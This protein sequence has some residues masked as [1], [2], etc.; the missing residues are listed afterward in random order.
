MAQNNAVS[1]T[2]GAA[3]KS[4]FGTALGGGRKQLMQMGQALKSLDASGKRIQ[5]FQKLK[6][7]VI[8]AKNSW[9][10]AETQVRELAL[11]M[12]Q[13]ANPTAKMK[14]EFEKAKN[15]AG[16][17]KAAY[18]KKQDSLRQVRLEMKA[19]GQSTRN[20]AAQQTKL[21]TS[22]D[23]LKS[24]YNALDR[25]LKRGDGIK[26]RRAAL[27]GQIL[28]MVALGAAMGA[29]L[30]AAIDFESEMADVRKVVDFKDQQNGLRAFGNQ[31]KAMSRTIPLSAAG[32]AQIAAAGG[33]LGVSED[34][35]PDFVKTASQMAVAFDIMPDQA[36]ESM[37]K[38]SNIFGIPITEMSQLGDALNH[39]SD[40]TA[41]KASEIVQVITR[42]GAQA[43]DFGLSAE[44][45]AALGDTFV[46]LGKK[47]EVAATAMNALLLKLNTADKQSAKF[48]SGLS[49]LGIEAQGLKDA[50]RNDAQG[51]LLSFLQ[52]VSQVEKQERA[53]ILSDLFGLEYADDISLLAGQVQTYQKTLD[54]LGDSKKHN[55]MQR[56][57]ANRSNTTKN[58]LQLLSNQITEIGMNIG[59]TLLPPLNFL[60]NNVMR[61]M[62]GMIADLAE[63]FPL[64][65]SVV[66]GATFALIGIKIAAIGLGY[67]WTFVL[68]GANALV[69]GFRGLQ[70]A[71]ALASL[72]MGAFNISA[73]IT[74][75]RLK[76]LAF[77]GMVKAFAASLI[78]L[79]SRAIPIVIG[80]MRALT[81][82]IMT[83]PIGLI[84]GGIALAGGLLITNWDKVKAFF[85]GIWDSV[86]PVWEAFA[87][88]IGG[89]W[90]IISAP[91]R[92]IGKVWD[93]IFGS[94][95]P[96]V[97]ATI[98]TKDERNTL[99]RSVQDAARGGMRQKSEHT[100][101]NAFNITVQAAPGQ[102]VSRIA[103][104]VMRRI[105]EQ[106][107][108]ALF[109]TAGAVL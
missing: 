78:G 17:A 70:S 24:K 2:I 55:S 61:P 31:L 35:L 18:E 41:A 36:G 88:W 82:A 3:L 39:L 46:A 77:G 74:A 51:A 68:G 16:R 87:D 42:A 12:K 91:I 57:F 94:N 23:R 44:Q 73:A 92:A 45:T 63:R 64:L 27:R 65:T 4:S 93:A 103:D 66:F 26:A 85:S 28:D 21:G 20:L 40:N 89:F 99:Q 80:G 75:V 69:V 38:L 79:A 105:K 71:L 34:A 11:A 83:N 8:A 106:T 60:V 6:T 52:T 108:G 90:K 19:A 37:A 102:D 15:A 49:A 30:K 67:A 104:E 50:I 25:A 9:Q 56:E 7:D 10:A 95:E 13:T 107:R 101:N 98:T 76:T 14:S 96:S 109:D 29:P 84:V 5:S 47:P 1:I 32:L 48:Q 54:L 33:Q 62:S 86:K 53:G 43:R 97:E 72:R 58:S 81:V 22:V 59:T 100:H